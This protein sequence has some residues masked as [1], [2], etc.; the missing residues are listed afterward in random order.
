MITDFY[1]AYNKKKT[2]F[3]LVADTIEDKTL[4]ALPLK[5]KWIYI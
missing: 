3:I 1:C 2:R 4:S 5:K